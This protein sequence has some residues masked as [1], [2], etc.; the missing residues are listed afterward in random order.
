MTDPKSLLLPS[1]LDLTAAENLRSILMDA[2]NGD[3]RLVID[4][5]VVHRVSSPCL[6]LLVAAKQHFG[7]GMSF[8]STSQA[9]IE[10]AVRL[11]LC[12]VL[13]LQETE[14]V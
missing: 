5:S 3:G 12:K 2:A 9:F 11:D 10:T 8:S 13:G 4:A 7:L 14:N 6:E 1:T